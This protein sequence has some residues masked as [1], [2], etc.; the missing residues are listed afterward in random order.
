MEDSLIDPWG[1]SEVVTVQVR[2]PKVRKDSIGDGG[3]DEAAAAEEASAQRKRVS[4]Q[5]QAAV[6]VEA[7]EDYARRFESGVN[8]VIPS[9][10]IALTSVC[11]DDDD[12]DDDDRENRFCLFVCLFVQLS[13]NDEELAQCG[14]NVMCRMCFLGESHGSERA[15]RMLSCKTCGKKYH[16]NC[17]KSWAQHRGTLL[18]PILLSLAAW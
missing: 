12:D 7:A 5:R 1:S 10:P 11:C 16:K 13:S 14:V 9:L 2:A 6:F 18:Y 15:R 4:L 8:E 17:V 3:V